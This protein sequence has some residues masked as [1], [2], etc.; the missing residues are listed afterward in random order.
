MSWRPL[1]N[2]AEGFRLDND[3]SEVSQSGQM[4]VSLREPKN[5]GSSPPAPQN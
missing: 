2:Q 5:T 4:S 1:C 3:R